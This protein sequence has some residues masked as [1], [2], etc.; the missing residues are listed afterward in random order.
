VW[1]VT[2]PHLNLSAVNVNDFSVAV[3]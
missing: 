2:V 3:L 1:Q